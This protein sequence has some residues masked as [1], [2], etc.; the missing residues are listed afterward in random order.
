MTKTNDVTELSFSNLLNNMK[1]NP[2]SEEANISGCEDEEQEQNHR[3]SK[4]HVF[5]NHSQF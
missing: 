1:V 2:L 3:L 4:W 5:F